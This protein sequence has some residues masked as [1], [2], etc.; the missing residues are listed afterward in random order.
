M[1][2]IRKKIGFISLAKWVDKY[3]KII[4]ELVG[5]VKFAIQV[6]IFEFGSVLKLGGE[7]ILSFKI[8]PTYVKLIS[9]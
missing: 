3:L 7:S 1:I 5:K 4:L 2:L 6:Q 9:S 8:L